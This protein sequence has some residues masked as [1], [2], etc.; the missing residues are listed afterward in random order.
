MNRI[1]MK[2]ERAAKGDMGC[3]LSNLEVELLLKELERLKA[4][5]EQTSKQTER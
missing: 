4:Y 1:L 3:Y 5:D 2:L